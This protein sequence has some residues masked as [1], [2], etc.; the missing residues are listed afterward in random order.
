MKLLDLALLATTI[1]ASSQKAQTTGTLSNSELAHLAKRYLKSNGDYKQVKQ[2]NRLETRI[3]FRVAKKA[4]RRQTKKLKKHLDKLNKLGSDEGNVPGIYARSSDSQTQVSEKADLSGVEAQL[5]RSYAKNAKC[6]DLKIDLLNNKKLYSHATLYGVNTRNFSKID[7]DWDGHVKLDYDSAYA[8]ACKGEQ[9]E[10]G[11]QCRLLCAD[12]RQDPQIRGLPRFLFGRRNRAAESKYHVFTCMCSQDERAREF[13]FWAMEEKFFVKPM[14]CDPKNSRISYKGHQKLEVINYPW[15]RVV[16]MTGKRRRRKPIYDLDDRQLT[17]WEEGLRIRAAENSV[18][19]SSELTDEVIDE[20]AEEIDSDQ[21]Q[22]A[23]EKA[24]T[25]ALAKAQEKSEQIQLQAIKSLQSD[26][27]KAAK[28]ALESAV[29]RVNSELIENNEVVTQAIKIE[30]AKI[31]AESIKLEADKAKLQA[32]KTKIEQEN[33]KIHSENAKIHVENAKIDVEKARLQTEVA[34]LEAVSA[35][36]EAEMAKAEAKKAI[37][38]AERL[39]AETEMAR[40]EADDSAAEAEIARSE[41]EIARNEAKVAKSEM[42]FAKSVANIAILESDLAKSEVDAAQLELEMAKRE[43]AIA[44]FELMT[45]QNETES[46]KKMVEQVENEKDE[47][48]YELK[49]AMK[50][51]SEL[52]LEKNSMPELGSSMELAPT[53]I[54]EAR[55]SCICEQPITPFPLIQPTTTQKPCPRQKVI[56]KSKNPVQYI[57]DSFITTDHTIRIF[58]KPDHC[59]VK[60]FNGFKLDDMVF[61]MNC[62]HMAENQLAKGQWRHDSN[63]GLVYNIRSIQKTPDNPYCW[64]VRDM[65]RKYHQV[66]RIAACNS[67]SDAQQFEYKKGRIMLKSKN[68]CVGL[69]AK[70]ES[71][72]MQVAMV[73]RCWSSYFGG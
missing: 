65:E 69:D 17:W 67:T 47:A 6:P 2:Q 11:S 46:L 37:A 62:S 42:E 36:S 12:K 15:E 44:Q 10:N 63:T 43:A 45:F 53:M 16:G 50:M 5:L 41:A 23:I 31:Q 19:V 22:E 71:R 3:E 8:P 66:L 48:V 55:D 64:Y 30:N 27:Q 13:C 39:K 40:A 70:K 58:G 54:P 68:L 38:E 51:I 1:T 14:S 28:E 35:K 59:L 4:A 32:D 49:T 29:E 21:I 57:S 24:V 61:A 20:I 56:I 9:N 34:N 72:N 60:R 52:E 7:Y 33:A 26:A 25:Q 18:E 73:G